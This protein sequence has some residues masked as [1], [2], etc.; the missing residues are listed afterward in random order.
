MELIVGGKKRVIP[1]DV[2]NVLSAQLDELTVSLEKRELSLA[3][4]ISLC[5]TNKHDMATLL[6]ISGFGSLATDIGVAF[7]KK[8][9]FPCPVGH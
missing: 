6:R 8:N 9:N 2:A 4:W 5:E 3:E 7:L 1:S